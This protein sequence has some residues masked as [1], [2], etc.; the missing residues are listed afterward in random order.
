MLTMFFKGRSKSCRI[1]LVEVVVY[2]IDMN[3]RNLITI[4]F[5]ELGVFINANHVDFKVKLFAHRFQGVKGIVTEM[6]SMS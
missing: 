5:K 2:P 1:Y 3:H 6:T 4:K